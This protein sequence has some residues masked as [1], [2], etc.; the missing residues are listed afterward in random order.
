MFK[1]IAIIAA[2]VQKA[3]GY[4][5]ETMKDLSILIKSTGLSNSETKPSTTKPSTTT[6][7]LKSDLLKITY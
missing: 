5:E 2:E 6:M 7:K 3:I 4:L 1:N